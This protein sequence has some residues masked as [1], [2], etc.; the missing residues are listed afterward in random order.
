MLRL[1]GT[2]L[3]SWD[4]YT[5][6]PVLRLVTYAALVYAGMVLLPIYI[7]AEPLVVQVLIIVLVSCCICRAHELM[8][9]GAVIAVLLVGTSGAAGYL[10]AVVVLLSG[11]AV[12]LEPQSLTSILILAGVPTVLIAVKLAVAGVSSAV[13]MVL[14]GMVLLL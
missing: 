14:L 2:W 11:V 9:T 3:L 5:S 12:S 10:Y 1:A 13:T 4:L 7:A 6:M 8:S